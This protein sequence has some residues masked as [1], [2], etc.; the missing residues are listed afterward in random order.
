MKKAASS[1]NGISGIGGRIGLHHA[2]VFVVYVEMINTKD[3][4]NK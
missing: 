3:V 4:F 2:D 1:I